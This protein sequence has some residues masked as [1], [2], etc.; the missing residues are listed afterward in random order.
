MVPP[1]S[2]ITNAPFAAGVGCWRPKMREIETTAVT[3][4]L[5]PIDFRPFQARA[6]LDR[7][8]ALEAQYGQI[9]ID[10]V[11]AALRHIKA[12]EERQRMPSKAAA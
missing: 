8:E 5:S 12:A 10:E 6:T 7:Q 4:H 1:Y 9:G 3:R 2:G 11:V